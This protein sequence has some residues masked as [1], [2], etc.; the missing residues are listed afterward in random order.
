MIKITDAVLIEDKYISVE[1]VR[2]PGPG[3]QNVNKVA[4]AVQLRVNIAECPLPEDLKARI[5]HLAGKRRVTTDGVVIITARRYRTQEGNR[6][7]A[8]DRLKALIRKACIKPRNRKKTKPT[9]ASKE[10]RLQSKGMKSRKKQDRMQI[11]SHDE[12]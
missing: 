8:F 9:A 2:S 3:G 7:D 10:R 5:V 4:T 11:M 6:K 1:F 12:A